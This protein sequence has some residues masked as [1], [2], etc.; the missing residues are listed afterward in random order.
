MFCVSA[1]SSLEVPVEITYLKGKNIEHIACGPTHSAA[2]SSDGQLY[3]WGRCSNMAALS[4][5]SSDPFSHPKCVSSSQWPHL[6]DVKCGA[7]C[8]TLIVL[9]ASGLF[10]IL[11]GIPF[12][13]ENTQQIVFI[14]ILNKMHVNVVIRLS[15][16]FRVGHF[17]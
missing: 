9:D 4:S 14:D 16:M 8:C 1:S 13:K 2:V 3:V 7:G 15:A 5:N 6:T 10:L 17:F 11:T 12:M